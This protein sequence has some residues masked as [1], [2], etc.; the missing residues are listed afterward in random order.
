MVALRG[1]IAA[2]QGK[3]RESLRL[4]RQAFPALGSA[5]QALVPEAAIELFYPLDYADTVR[6]LGRAQ[7]LPAHLVLAMIHQESGFDAQAK[8]RSGARGLMQVMPATGREVARRLKLSYSTTRLFEPDYSVRLG[9]FYFRQVLTMFDGNVELALAGYNGGPNRIRQL[10]Q[11]AG[12]QA[13]MD[14]FLEGLTLEESKNYV[15]RILALSDTY[16]RLYPE[17]G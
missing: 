12:P 5:H 13:E 11:R 15:K 3:R 17:L 9:T 1:V 8:S 14:R 10:W 16:R 4:I 7:G 2:H 6:A